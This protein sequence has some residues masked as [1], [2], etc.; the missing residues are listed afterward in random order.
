MKL[1]YFEADFSQVN[2]YES[3]KQQAGIGWT[4]GLMTKCYL[5]QW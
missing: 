1:L 3:D 2:S 5:N 4:N